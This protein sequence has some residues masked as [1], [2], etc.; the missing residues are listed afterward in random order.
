MSKINGCPYNAS[1]NNQCT[2]KGC[3][4][5]KSKKRYCGYGNPKECELYLEW[6]SKREKIDSRGVSDGL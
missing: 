6:D 3:K 1:N 5:Y 4:H 2:H